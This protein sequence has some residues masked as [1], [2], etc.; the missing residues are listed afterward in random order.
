[1]NNKGWKPARS[2]ATDDDI[3]DLL[4]FSDDAAKI[5]EAMARAKIQIDQNDRAI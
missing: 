3:L 5:D 4:E 1:M 2:P